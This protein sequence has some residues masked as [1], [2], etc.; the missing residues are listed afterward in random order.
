ML[1]WLP[2][3][4]LQAMC[5]MAFWDISAGMREQFLQQEQ[6]WQQQQRQQ[7][8]QQEGEQRS[9]LGKACW[10][11]AHRSA[12]MTARQYQERRRCSIPASSRV[13]WEH[14]LVSLPRGTCG[15]PG[16]R[17]ELESEI[18][19]AYGFN[20]HLQVSAAAVMML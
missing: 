4:R 17:V 8:E 16:V 9:Q 13:W 10:A 15:C 3:Q 14:A 1:G 20:C 7:D 18:A 6:R 12:F 11:A 5:H 2:Q 19:P